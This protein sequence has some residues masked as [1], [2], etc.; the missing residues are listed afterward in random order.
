MGEE[1]EEANRR[2]GRSDEE[3]AHFWDT[4]DGVLARAREQLNAL[5]ESRFAEE[6]W[7]DVEEPNEEEM[8]AFVQQE[9]EAR[10]TVHAH[11]LMVVAQR[12][13]NEVAQWLESA[14]PDIATAAESIVAQARCEIEVTVGTARKDF[15]ELE[16]MID[17]VTWYHTLL[18]PKTYRLLHGILQEG[19]ASEI[20]GEDTL[21]TAKLLLVSADRCLAAWKR[22][23]EYV[24][25]Q[26]GHILRFLVMLDRFRRGIEKEI[27]AAR[28]HRRPGLDG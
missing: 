17:V 6:F 22:I 16:E 10:R 3:N 11:P 19:P 25:S 20:D 13:R 26:E 28:P 24:P 9:E 18:Q 12:Y 5:A 14:K 4:T 23:L 2:K 15:D 8:R 7:D 27:H 1:L 21:G